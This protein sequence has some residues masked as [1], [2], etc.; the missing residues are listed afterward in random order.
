MKIRMLKAQTPAEPTKK[1]VQIIEYGEVISYTL[2]SDWVI[3]DFIKDSVP[4]RDC[5]NASSVFEFAVIGM[6]PDEKKETKTF[7]HRLFCR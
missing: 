7:L 6:P 2:T 5:F 4:R 3:I 1:L